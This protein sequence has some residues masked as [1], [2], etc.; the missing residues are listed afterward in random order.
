MVR[1]WMLVYCGCLVSP[2][3]LGGSREFKYQLEPPP[4]PFGPSPHALSAPCGC[5]VFRLLPKLSKKI[6][7]KMITTYA[8]HIDLFTHPEERFACYFAMSTTKLKK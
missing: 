2:A 3:E 5:G 7:K 6:I 4:P 8:H 1:W